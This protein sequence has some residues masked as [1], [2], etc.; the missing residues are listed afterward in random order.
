MTD[1]KVNMESRSEKQIK[2]EATCASSYERIRKGSTV[3]NRA[4]S[5]IGV[6][7]GISGDCVAVA[8]RCTVDG[9]LCVEEVVMRLDDCRP[10]SQGEKRVLQ[11]L[12]NGSRLLWDMRQCRLKKND[13]IPRKGARVQLSTLGED[14]IIGVFKEIDAGG[15]IVMYC[16]MHPGER[17]VYSMHEVAGVAADFQIQPVG[18]T[19]RVKFD[20]ALAA[21]GV[22]WNGHLRNVEVAGNR[23]SRGQVYYYLDEYLEIRKARDAYKPRDRKRR[24]AGNYFVS[25][26][27]IRN[28]RECFVS[29]LRVQHGAE[30]EGRCVGKSEVEG[31]GKKK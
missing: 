11:R 30:A 3:V 18:S 7:G 21:E 15:H 31:R 24:A 12:L 10:A 6:V 25:P 1:G 5:E 17:P 20:R 2:S 14:V 4:T 28:V 19:A 8:A 29:V 13:Y 16:M 23:P 27:A 9:E 26:E 22:V